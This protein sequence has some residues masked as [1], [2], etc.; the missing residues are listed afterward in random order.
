[1]DN[2]RSSS[3]YEEPRN[4]DDTVA[5]IV[6]AASAA[7]IVTTAFGLPNV[8]KNLQKHFPSGMGNNLASTML[9]RESTFAERMAIFGKHA[10]E[11]SKD[12]AI[13]G[14]I[15][16]ATM[17]RSKLADLDKKSGVERN[18]NMYAE[19]EAERA[20]KKNQM[21]ELDKSVEP[22]SGSSL[23]ERVALVDK[24]ISNKDDYGRAAY[25]RKP[26]SRLGRERETFTFR[27]SAMNKQPASA[28]MKKAVVLDAIER[29]DKP[30]RDS[31]FPSFK[32][33]DVSQARNQPLE[34]FINDFDLAMQ[35]HSPFAKDIARGY[36]DIAANRRRNLLL[37]FTYKGQAITLGSV[38][39]DLVGEQRLRFRWDATS[40]FME[41]KKS[42]EFE[43]IDKF[44][45][46]NSNPV[47]NI[48]TSV[49]QSFQH[50]GAKEYGNSR[51][52]LKR[53]FDSMF[54]E[55]RHLHPSA[56]EGK[57]FGVKIDHKQNKIVLFA[58]HDKNG[59]KIT[60][61]VALNIPDSMRR[62]GH[63]NSTRK[64]DTSAIVKHGEGF[65]LGSSFERTSSEYANA[66]RT[67]VHGLYLEPDPKG[68]EV[69]RLKSLVFRLQSTDQPTGNSL[70]DAYK[71]SV[72]RNTNPLVY[73]KSTARMNR[74]VGVTQHTLLAAARK[75]GK[76][77][78]VYDQ[79]FITGRE[80][81]NIVA[82][83]PHMAYPY[84]VTARRISA[85]GKELPGKNYWIK[86]DQIKEVLRNYKTNPDNLEVIRFKESLRAINKLD[87]MEEILEQISSHGVSAEH[88]YKDMFENYGAGAVRV[89]YGGHGGP[90]WAIIKHQSG[91]DYFNKGKNLDIMKVMRASSSTKLGWGKDPQFRKMVLSASMSDQAFSKLESQMMSY[92]G[93]KSHRRLIR[94]Y[95]A[96]LK[97]NP[98]NR[99]KIFIDAVLAEAHDSSVDVAME[100]G[101]LEN[102]ESHN[103]LMGLPG[104][105]VA[106]VD[107]LIRKSNVSFRQRMN[108]INRH[109]TFRHFGDQNAD[110]SVNNI[111]PTSRSSNQIMS[112]EYAGL[113]A[114]T[115]DMFQVGNTGLKQTHQLFHTYNLNVPDKYRKGRFLSPVVS[116]FRQTI[117]SYGENAV[118]NNIAA[119][120]E[121][122]LVKAVLMPGGYGDMP[123]GVILGEKGPLQFFNRELESDTSKVLMGKS[124]EITDPK[125]KNFIN[126]VRH[127]FEGEY[128]YLRNP[129]GN[130][131]LSPDF[132]SL[133]QR[134]IEETDDFVAR[135][136]KAGLIETGSTKYWE[137]RQGDVIARS[138]FGVPKKLVHD[139]GRYSY[140]NFATHENGAV[141]M[142]FRMKRLVGMEKGF[143]G[144][145]KGMFKL[146]VND[147]EAEVVGS[148]PYQEADKLT[149]QIQ[150]P[151]LAVAQN[152]MDRGEFGTDKKALVM[153]AYGEMM[154]HG[155]TQKAKNFLQSLGVSNVVDTPDGPRIITDMKSIQERV[156][157]LNN[158]T[159]DKLYHGHMEAGLTWGRHDINL[160]AELHK[161]NTATASA[162]ADG[163][164]RVVMDMWN[165]D[166]KNNQLKLIGGGNYTQTLNSMMDNTELQFI[167]MYNPYYHP[168]HG[169][170]DPDKIKTARM[171][172]DPRRM[173][174]GRINN[175]RDT[176]VEVHTLITQHL[177]E[178]GDQVKIMRGGMFHDDYIRSKDAAW[179]NSFERKVL[180]RSVGSYRHNLRSTVINM[181][182]VWSGEEAL[183]G[184]GVRINN[185]LDVIMQRTLT[186]QEILNDMKNGTISKEDVNADLFKTYQRTAWS[187]ATSE[188]Y[189]MEADRLD[190]L[191]KLDR[192]T[193]ADKKVYREQASALRKRAQVNL[194]KPLHDFGNS[195]KGEDIVKQVGTLYEKS[196]RTPYTHEFAKDSVVHIGDAKVSPYDMIILKAP[197][198]V[199]NVGNKEFYKGLLDHVQSIRDG[200]GE[201]SSR[202]VETR[203][204]VNR[205][206][207]ALTKFLASG[208][209]GTIVLPSSQ[210]VTDIA[211]LNVKLMESGV[212]SES[213]THSYNGVLT[214]ISE[215]HNA[216]AFEFYDKN[217]VAES[218]NLFGEK[219]LMSIAGKRKGKGFSLL[220]SERQVTLGGLYTQLEAHSDAFGTIDR[221]IKDQALNA[222]KSP[223]HGGELEIGEQLRMAR[224]MR[225][226]EFGLMS[227]DKFL[228]MKVGDVSMGMF[229]KK[230]LGAKRTLSILQ[231][232]E[233]VPLVTGRHPFETNDMKMGVVE[234]FIHHDKNRIFKDLPKGIVLGQKVLEEIKG[235]LDGDKASIAMADIRSMQEYDQF[236]ASY[237]NRRARQN[238]LI[239][240]W[241]TRALETGSYGQAT[242]GMMEEFKKLRTEGRD[243]LFGTRV[244]RSELRH[245]AKLA[246]SIT[247][248]GIIRTTA[249]DEASG[250]YEERALSDASLADSNLMRFMNHGNMNA[251]AEQVKKFLTPQD[252]LTYRA[253]MIA[254]GR[255]QTYGAHGIGVVSS[256]AT[257]T[258]IR[259]RAAQNYL[260][261]LGTRAPS[262]DMIKDLKMLNMFSDA[263]FKDPNS[264]GKKASQLFEDHLDLMDDVIDDI[265]TVMRDPE[266]FLISTK[267]MTIKDAGRHVL[268]M[269]E[270]FPNIW[271][272]Q[273]KE[274][275]VAFGMGE[276]YNETMIG[277]LRAIESVAFAIEK[278]DV[279]HAIDVNSQLAYASSS[280]VTIPDLQTRVARDFIQRHSSSLSSSI[281]EDLA[282]I[283]Q[284]EMTSKFG[285]KAS[286]AWRN[287]VKQLLHMN[288]S[289]TLGGLALG[290]GLLN[291]GNPNQMTGGVSDFGIDLGHRPG[292][293]SESGVGIESLSPEPGMDV[294]QKKWTYLLKNDPILKDN[295]S[296][297][298]NK[299]YK[300][301]TMNRKSY[302]MQ[303]PSKKFKRN[304]IDYRKD[305]SG[306]YETND[307]RRAVIP[308]F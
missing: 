88:A 70:F 71:S 144:S 33:F 62:T 304:Y 216:A 8:W 69:G 121:S 58:I 219:L 160:M 2:Y 243:D 296:E 111:D 241:Q 242:E 9:K 301:L 123:E 19:Q 166:N 72:I 30:T 187:K 247:K 229:L 251:S 193:D 87:S 118:A 125:L 275:R 278:H 140:L 100:R 286:G 279:Q 73:Q 106:G 37:P 294:Y 90:D 108:I 209:H 65:I 25:R 293:K 195:I 67:F 10:V 276:K 218:L 282:P 112:G 231:G 292:F 156:K 57:E 131:W 139:T 1:M 141:E 174:N 89:D 258:A 181:L 42:P 51:Q 80:G 36:L 196:N 130:F 116:A 203:A 68:G 61:E 265:S 152:F 290:I 238:K 300:N 54:T 20:A 75:S 185:G 173:E 47:D 232:K 230:T 124:G 26:S 225:S 220:Y 224:L 188:K 256:H 128:E 180:Q 307:M 215:S 264:L 134:Y 171:F 143:V 182:G 221:N 223:F 262:E 3:E 189:L 66:F 200:M 40:N 281:L 284:T 240:N 255:L 13:I 289:K 86:T 39:D 94:N 244:T 249:I 295:M 167:R 59:R 302:G 213:L 4:N 228:K 22:I 239:A 252:E 263:D 271:K 126:K 29:M 197:N 283:A 308:S 113:G 306:R 165:R 237:R 287:S 104:S 41:D 161:V 250:I 63:A 32:S 53:L 138:Q 77:F 298:S 44:M 254:K 16:A 34:V 74:S 43:K 259:M 101:L 248:V 273:F 99:R 18:L 55:I 64:I 198:S 153:R 274:T 97:H 148:R 285:E 6:R 149:R 120:A 11:L 291:F 155:Q 297:L 206:T 12:P 305:Y 49:D 46:G 191:T 102:I 38:R 269:V 109:V 234:Y 194:T 257:R 147:L 227:R 136:M 288:S 176:W 135:D 217:R 122:V 78:L 154:V 92:A 280:G 204:R 199:S 208:E 50:I 110:E 261:K 211:N 150:R 190:S 60:Q 129:K 95:Q 35:S 15:A 175:S 162:A 159:I 268:T 267:K 56:R 142:A 186:N 163:F 27:P 84:Q 214:A 183:G 270:N 226:G 133:M 158:I 179:G 5:P 245:V 303:D 299:S 157:G 222:S 168:K 114:S 28:E 91:V 205:I 184:K 170:V 14:E 145:T 83:N 246:E 23:F 260:S 82:K 31:L 105:S 115:L 236:Q 127:R 202:T 151:M 81:P 192:I 24:T 137:H 172:V 210:M 21:A 17:E 233:V 52:N 98:S 103:P 96:Q 76:D 164:D 85:S 7:A 177:Q 207:D 169:I 277:K 79:E 146:S 132:Q 45:F 107:D 266:Q 201:S 212:A 119:N 93:S 178:P 253:E 48:M 117:K 272:D 235:D